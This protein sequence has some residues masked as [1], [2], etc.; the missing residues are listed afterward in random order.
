MDQWAK[1][2]LTYP[3]GFCGLFTGQFRAAGKFRHAGNF[4]QVAG[5]SRFRVVI[6]ISYHVLM[7][8]IFDI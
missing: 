5:Y 2:I 7:Q 6:F 4:K 8:Y 3:D 1:R